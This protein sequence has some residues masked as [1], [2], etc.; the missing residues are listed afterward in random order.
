MQFNSEIK[1]IISLID[2]GD[3]TNG[4]SKLQATIKANPD[5]APLHN[6][7]GLLLF[8]LGGQLEEAEKAFEKALALDE[9]FGPTYINYTAL[10]KANANFE[11]VPSIL[12]KALKTTP[13]N[14]SRIF[15]EMGTAFEMQNKY[16]EAISHYTEAA[17]YSLN[18]REIATMAEAIRR[19][20]VKRQIFTD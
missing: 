3:F 18:N 10:L 12:Q 17:K 19:C 8:R 20:E 6:L 16:L 13:L 14:K 7:E 4:L 15:Y 11:K 1:E 5:S 2:Q 9:K